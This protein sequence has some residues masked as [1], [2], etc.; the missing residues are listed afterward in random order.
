MI[1]VIL[2][3]IYG[4][5]ICIYILLHCKWS[6]SK[7]SNLSPSEL[8]NVKVVLSCISQR[9]VLQCFAAFLSMSTL[10]HYTIP[11]QG[12]ACRSSFLRTCDQLL[13]FLPMRQECNSHRG[14]PRSLPGILFG[15]LFPHGMQNCTKPSCGSKHQGQGLATAC[16]QHRGTK[17]VLSGQYNMVSIEIAKA[18]R[19]ILHL[20]K[21]VAYAITPTTIQITEQFNSTL[22]AHMFYLTRNNTETN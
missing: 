4:F 20:F 16:M 21:G 17:P 1:S 9:R 3:Y 19:V 10:C 7:C 2:F 5:Q 18:K 14:V 22:V 6:I 8:G 12:S 15:A 13:V 11:A